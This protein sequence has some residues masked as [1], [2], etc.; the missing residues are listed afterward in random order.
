MHLQKP[1]QKGRVQYRKIQ[2]IEVEGV[3]ARLAHQ[4][5][6][7]TRLLQTEGHCLL[8]PKEIGLIRKNKNLWYESG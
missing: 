2:K 8:A 3:D 4:V 6:L 5:W 7:A 1:Q